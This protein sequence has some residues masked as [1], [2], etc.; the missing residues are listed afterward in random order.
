M[1]SEA[2]LRMRRVN[3]QKTLGW[4]NQKDTHKWPYRRSPTNKSKAGQKL[5]D[6]DSQGSFGSKKFKL[7]KNN[8][9]EPSN[10]GE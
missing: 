1:G 2:N 10:F 5:R 7:K 8:S 4:K 9:R 6:G 3:R